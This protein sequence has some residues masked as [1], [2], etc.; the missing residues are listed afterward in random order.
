MGGLELVVG[1]WRVWR[2]LFHVKHFLYW[3]E[4]IQVLHFGL[5]M[6]VI[7]RLPSSFSFFNNCEQVFVLA[8]KI[9]GVVFV[10]SRNTI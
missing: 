8:E 10:V 1:G 4:Q 3:L 7:L 9:W 6:L 5:Q 2:Q